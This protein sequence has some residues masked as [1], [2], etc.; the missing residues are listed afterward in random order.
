MRLT[1]KLCGALAAAAFAWIAATACALA[2]ARVAL[3]IGE[4]GY[5]SAPAL[6]NPPNDAHD[7]A[8]A[9]RAIGFE[10]MLKVDVD[11]AEMTRA[12]AEFGARAAHADL[13][14][15]Y[16]GGHGLQLQDHNYLAP[17]DTV[18]RNAADI[19]T[20]TVPLDSVI[21]AMAK[22]PGRRLV[23]LDACR[24][25]PLKRGDSI[26]APAGLARVG[27]AAD[28][29]IAFATQPDA[30]AFDGAGRNSPFAQALLAHL[31][32]GGVDLSNTM[33]A[34]RRDVIAATGGEQVP[35]E[36]SSLTKQ[37]YLAGEGAPDASPEAALWRLAAPG[38]DADL[39]G[40]Y[41]QR[42]PAGPHAADVRAL[43]K[44]ASAA[45]KPKTRSA[46]EEIWRLALS[47]REPALVELY[48]ARFPEGAHARDAEDL[49]EKLAEAQSTAKDP[50]VLCDRLAT[51][52]N[53]ATAS[54][55]GVDL[56]TLKVNAPTAIEACEKALAA[57]P[58]SAH[59]QALLARA[60]FAADQFDQA[61]KLY[62]AAA[63][64]GDARA[65]VSLGRLEETGDHTPKD[66][67]G[68]YRLYEKAA[69]RGSPDGAIN[70]A[71][72]LTEG[73]VMPKDL[74]RA[75]ELLKRS[76]DAGSAIATFDLGKFAD[77]GLGGKAAD[78]LALYRRAAALGEPN[79]Y[80]AAA[81]LLDEGRHTPKSPDGAADE[82]LRA[83][84]ADSGLAINELTGPTQSWT[85]ATVSAMQKRLKAAGYYG[86]AIDGRSGPALAPA[87]KR[88]RLLGDPRSLSARAAK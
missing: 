46:E 40:I 58:G 81:V 79:G 66:I 82:L 25:N 24:E 87:L 71:V 4:G 28:F 61:V 33:I 2:Q 86:G 32:T 41:L 72:A 78:A 35:W 88:W 49:A 26:P 12:I 55:P 15:F 36:N 73:K 50:G 10:V 3:V 62:R 85:P 47:S 54:A 34:V 5:R 60:R 38:R 8:Q 43:L 29:M 19:T 70:V 67:A 21:A 80:R 83:V 69:D 42:Y 17:V 27:Q 68:A 59:Y 1:A 53:D 84:T 7:I 18:L 6:A 48:R 74:G 39:L 11:Q 13:A 44:T 56:A 14:L 63:E 31:T 20:H 64:A 16:Y 30:V 75:Y 52:P 37:I 57:S 77:D 23:F 51:H 76:A 22:S 65:L 45:P 9:L